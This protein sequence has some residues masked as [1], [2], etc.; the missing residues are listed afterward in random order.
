MD[1]VQRRHDGVGHGQGRGDGQREM[2]D[3]LAAT[4]LRGTII[5]EE[6]DCMFLQQQ[7]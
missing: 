2:E 6:E 1:R 4:P 3:P 5:L 7:Q